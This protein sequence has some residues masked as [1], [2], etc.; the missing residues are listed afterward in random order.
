MEKY[1]T[2]EALCCLDGNQELCEGKK[3][4]PYLRF[5]YLQST[6][7]ILC[8]ESYE[9]IEDIKDI[10]DVKDILQNLIKAK[11]T[12][13]MY[14]QNNPI[15]VKT[16]EDSYARFKSFFDYKEDLIL[17]IKQNSI[18]YDSEQIYYNPE[19]EDNMALLFFKDGLRELTFKKGLTQEELEEFLKIIAMDFDRE[20]VDDDI[21]T[22][23]WEKDFQNIQYIVDETFLVDVDEEDYETKVENE[24]K[25]KIT[26]VDDLM[27]AYADGFKEEDVK[28]ISIVPLTDKDL[29]MLVKELEKDSSD[30][31]DKLINILF[32]IVYQSE[33]KAELEDT[34]ISL[35]DAIKFSMQHGDIYMVLNVLKR[36][37]EMLEDPLLTEDV[38]EYIRML[39][40][41]LGTE[42]IISLF[43]EILDSGIEIDEKAF[44]EFGKFLDKN[45]IAPLVKFLGEMKTIHARKR[46]IEALIFLGRKDIHAVARGLDDHRW[47]VVRNIIYIL[48]KIGDKRA[49]E[50]LLRTVRHGDT[51][52]R[53]EVI[54]ALGELGGREVVQT[55]RECLD[56]QDAQVRIASARAFSN[57]G[58]EPAKKIIL[59]KISDKMF[60]DRDFEEKKEFYE[61][62]SRWKDAEVFDFLI[63]TLNKK[64]FFS[65]AKNYENMAC[66]A[67]SLGLLGDKDAL[68]ILYKYKDSNN[69]LLREFSSAAIK[70]IEYNQ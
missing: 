56:D 14:P 68:P 42:E 13:R 59:E 45:A 62:L 24:I 4:S 52:V 49:I 55:L 8:M 6:V 44:E 60:K 18:S 40:S 21:V 23:L 61:V 11:K 16:L 38:K 70:R 2:P 17:K 41:Y 32:E 36:A 28:G 33:G 57:I 65:R 10:K 27:R 19:K 64:S 22:L 63:R 37:K 54:R 43:A 31:T 3:N 50:Y 15:Y 29:Q 30:K 12:L 7:V 26:D 53:K 9:D 48:R 67:F 35:K 47:Y 39:F 51:R 46:V 1:K 69:K 34:F 66:A 5:D 20:A 58:S 25:E